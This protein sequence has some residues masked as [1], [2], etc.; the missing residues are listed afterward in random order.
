M[1]SNSLRT[2]VR[3]L[4]RAV[5]PPVM[6]GNRDTDLVRAFAG[7]RD[8]LA[9][10]QIV[11]RHGPMVLG[12][13]R[14]VLR[15]PADADDAFQATFLVLL[16]RAGSL[17]EPDRLA[18]WLHQ[19]AHRTAR[20]L[21]SMR[22]ARAARQ[23]ELSDVAI[24]EPPAEF[25]WR[26]LRP[27]FDQELDQLPE[28]LRLPAVL[29]FL[30]GHSKGEAA[31]TLGWP[32]GTLSGRLQQARERLR[33]RF[34]ARGLTLSTGALAAALFEGVGSA[35]VTDRLLT[36]TI[37]IA[38]GPAGATASAT[39]WTLADGVSH[40]MFMTK[41]KALAAAVLV[42]GVIGTGTGV[43]L[44]PGAGSGDVVAAEPVKDAPKDSKEPKAY[45]FK[46]GR[47]NVDRI[48]IELTLTELQGKSDTQRNRTAQERLRDK[49]LGTI[50]EHI[51]SLRAEN[52]RMAQLL[53]KGLVAK[54]EAD[55]L[56]AE[57]RAAEAQ[58]AKFK[59]QGA[60]DPERTALVA[61]LEALKERA[62]WEE[63]M[64]KKGFMTAN[65]LRATQAKIAQLETDLARL[66]AP[67]A[68]D[69]RRAAM[70]NLIRKMEEI[71]E[72]TE[73]GVKNGIVPQQELLNAQRT[74]LEYRFRLAELKDRSVIEAPKAPD[75][76]RAAL[77]DVVRKMEIIVDKVAEGVRKGIV[78]QQELLNAERTVLEHKFKLLDLP[79]RPAADLPKPSP[80]Q[81]AAI[82]DLIRKMEEIVQK[83]A[84]GVKKGIVP[85]SELFNAECALLEYRYRLAELTHQANSDTRTDRKAAVAER[86]KAEI[87][88]KERELGR[89]KVLLREQAISQGEVR[90][91]TIDLGRLKAA[92][93]EAAGDF[94]ESLRHR[95]GVVAEHEALT[96]ETKRL[97]ARNT[98]SQAELRTAEVALAEARV[99][100]LAAGIRRQLA[101]VVELRDQEVRDARKLF[102]AKVISAVE[103]RRAEQ[104][105]AEA[106]A[107][108][109]QVR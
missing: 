88:L 6:R 70:E 48:V 4:R 107:R 66:D 41:A 13:C 68:P 105:L 98:V 65:Q 10:E 18:G 102:D 58:L 43:V 64:V 27:I 61:D 8:P 87:D 2:V 92:A 108:L 93:A 21:R 22:L 25:I 101:A 50:E 39:V 20:K 104:A 3:R 56:Q 69:S 97:A 40:A 100:A 76:R 53:A 60:K 37:Q 46:E 62:S 99:E 7:R 78:P 94:G 32:E 29:C 86:L 80:A 47:K 90:R 84:E 12:V 52:E 77:E 59:A 36:S 17:R 85:E 5:A 103:L 26:E 55:A 57:L 38:S 16:R 23:T 31:R 30:E 9:F 14:R 106:R 49:L 83:T 1:Q 45:D 96:T 28:K 15:D 72:K 79:E 33:L 89:A 51:K 75:P 109:A 73:V 67:K 81:R 91:L 74:L 54:T 44:V 63:Q 34:A 11:R 71:V 95:E 82:E 35:A 24:G 19:V 42:A